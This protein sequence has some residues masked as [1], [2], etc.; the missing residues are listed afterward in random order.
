MLLALV[1][2]FGDEWMDG[3]VFFSFS[4][5]HC[6]CYQRGF[7]R[8]CCSGEISGFRIVSLGI[9]RPARGGGGR[10]DLRS[11]RSC[12]GWCNSLIAEFLIDGDNQQISWLSLRIN[13]VP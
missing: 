3:W 13:L 6:A 11:L 1:S 8:C 4:F 9:A 2:G 7:G 10:F 12:H 5:L